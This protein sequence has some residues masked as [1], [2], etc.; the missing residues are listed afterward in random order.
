Q[1]ASAAG[2]RL[3]EV[4]PYRPREGQN[5]L[6]NLGEIVPETVAVDR[7][8]AKTGAERIVVRAQAIKQRPEVVELREIAD[9]DRAATHLVLVSGADAAAC[10]PDLARSARVLAQPVEVAVD[11][12]DQGAIVGDHQDVGA[13]VDALLTDALHLIAKGPGVEHDAIADHRRRAADDAAW[14]QRQL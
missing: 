3:V 2:A 9:A 14:Q 6:R 4:A 10:C 8:L 13:D 11:R 5:E 1:N 12:Q 7:R